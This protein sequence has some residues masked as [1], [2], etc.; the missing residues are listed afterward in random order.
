[1]RVDCTLCS[2]HL[3]PQPLGLLPC[4][5][6]GAPPG[7]YFSSPDHSAGQGGHWLPGGHQATMMI[8]DGISM[9]LGKGKGKDKDGK[10][11]GKD[12][13]KKG[14][15][16]GKGP[17]A[18][19]Y[20]VD[21]KIY[22]FAEWKLIH[23]GGDLFFAPASQRDISAAVHAY[24]ENPERLKPILD[25]YEVKLPEGKEP[26][27]ILVKDLGVPTFILPPDFDAVKHVPIYD[28]EGKG[29]MK[30]LRKKIGTPDMKKR[31]RRADF[32]FD[33]VGAALFTLHVLISFPV[34]AY[35][36]LPCWL[37][38]FL[39]IVLRQAVA[40]LGHYHCHRTKNGILDW[41]DALFDIQYIGASVILTDGHVM[42][43]HLYT[44]TPADV[45]RTVFN[46]MLTLPRL[47][48]LPLFTLQKFGEFFSGH[49]FRIGL[50]LP[51]YEDAEKCIQ[52]ELQIRFAR[53]YMLFE[54]YYCYRTGYLHWWVVQFCL[55]IWCSMFQIVAS[56][57][58][59]VVREQDEHRG[60][61]WGIH[62]VTHSLD[63]YITGIRW[64]DIW[65]SAGLSCHRV[66][67][68]LPYQRSGFANIV[69]EDAVKET[70]KEF[71]VEWMPTRNRRRNLS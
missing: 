16:K 6:R 54:L 28:W 29:F 30:S 27:D 21:G 69:C 49:L 68:V 65:L 60:M 12:K 13:E 22:N 1:M 43:H 40:A 61:D 67:H 20:Y 55:C 52:K 23:P 34:L 8:M 58:F 59:E 7:A 41:G 62:Q 44:E 26:R 10:G 17:F 35:G 63:T 39:Q 18:D 42:L 15:G 46:F 33:V 64:V 71:D 3:R 38:V 70:C 14:K 48:R 5:F 31:I 50:M 66:H 24:H 51:C 4:S 56:H 37:W 45:K 53:F 9:L 36:M 57:D 2:P 32:W 25:K 11:K 47:W 19:H